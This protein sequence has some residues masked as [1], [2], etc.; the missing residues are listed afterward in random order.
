MLLRSPELDA[1]AARH[2]QATVEGQPDGTSVVTVPLMPLP[3][4]WNQATTTVWFVLPSAYPAAQPDCFFADERLALASGSAPAN[5]GLQAVLGT[6]RLW[7][8]W[9]LASWDPNRD[10]LMSYLRF[11]ESRFRN[12]N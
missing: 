7:F 3:A 5:S 9:H 2:P 1:L 12:V 6:Q 8:S 11:I 4:G 10:D